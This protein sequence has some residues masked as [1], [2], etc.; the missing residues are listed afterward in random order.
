MCV[1]HGSALKQ[2]QSMPY[3]VAA[4]QAAAH[5]RLLRYSSG[6][7]GVDRRSRGEAEVMILVS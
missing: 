5:T 1:R 4:S 2:L 3:M 6:F 7:G